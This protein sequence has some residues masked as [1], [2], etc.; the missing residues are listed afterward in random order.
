MQYSNKKKDLDNFITN[1]QII[2]LTSE[3]FNIHENVPENKE[4]EVI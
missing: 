2:K 3:F 4:E 1:K